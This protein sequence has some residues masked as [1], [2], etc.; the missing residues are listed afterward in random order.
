MPLEMM[1]YVLTALEEQGQCLSNRTVRN[2]LASMEYSTGLG[3]ILTDFIT[4]CVIS[5]YRKK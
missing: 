4:R 1:L 2:N 3:Q 5:H